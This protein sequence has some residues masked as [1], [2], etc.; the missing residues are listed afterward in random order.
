MTPTPFRRT[1]SAAA[2]AAIAVAAPALAGLSLDP[3]AEATSVFT[4][5]AEVLLAALQDEVAAETPAASPW[6]SKINAGGS[7]SF[8]NTDKQDAFAIFTTQRERD[9]QRTS[10][11][12]GYFY[13]ATDGDRSDNKFEASLR[14]DWLFNGSPWS[15]FAQAEY[16][17]DE[18]QSWEHRVT[19]F[20]GVGLGPEQ[21]SAE[22]GNLTICSG[23]ARSS[24]CKALVPGL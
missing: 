12:A 10:V 11:R 21:D 5:E 7:A 19:G 3:D 8:G 15:V 22:R 6:K 20:V 16:K 17:Y 1:R 14:N 18:F 2:L 4:P 9:D 23:C 24:G 13:G